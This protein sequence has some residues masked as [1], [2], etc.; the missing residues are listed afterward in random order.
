MIDIKTIEAEA[1]KEL[2]EEVAKLA[3]SKI[4]ASLKRI[5]DAEKILANARLEHAALMRDIGGEL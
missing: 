4:K 5:Q 3:R 2:S 1:Q